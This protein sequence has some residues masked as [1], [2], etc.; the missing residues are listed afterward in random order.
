MTPLEA[1]LELLDRVGASRDAA[2]LVSEEE[3]SRWPAEAVRELKAKKLLQRASPAVSVV[4]PGCEQECVMPVHT[5]SAGAGTAASF[6][7]CDKRDD[8]SRVAVSVERLRQWRCGAEAVSTFVAQ[9][10]GLR[11]GNR[12][13]TDAGLWELGLVTGKRR[14]QMVCLRVNGALELAAGQNAV[15]LAELVRF[16][17]DDFSVDCEA[18]RQLS[19]RR[20]GPTFPPTTAW[21]IS[22]S[23]ARRRRP[24][25]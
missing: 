24:I 4:C 11:S 1:L 12:R 18:V 10:L 17:V 8:I 3:L 7:V 5:P 6:V 20:P 19:I 21:A 9:S 25:Q 2:V 13:I 23:L 15:P 16:G 14:S 22:P